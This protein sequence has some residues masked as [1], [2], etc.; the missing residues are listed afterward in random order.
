MSELGKQWGDCSG[1]DRGSYA[2]QF[3]QCVQHT[4][5]GLVFDTTPNTDSTPGFNYG[6]L[7][8]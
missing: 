7:E 4:P 8:A 5:D 2:I 6:K 1:H 3:N